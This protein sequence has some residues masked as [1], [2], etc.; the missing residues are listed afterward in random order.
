MATSVK[1][2]AATKDRLEEL[3]ALIKL[4][5]GTKVTQQELLKVLVDEAY[6]SRDEIVDHFR[7]DEWEG[8][9]D[10]E[11]QEWLSGTFSAGEPIGEDEDI[12]EIIYREELENLE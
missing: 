4:E 8:L 2:D 3:Q 7:D 6:S 9:S 1:M 12:D 11:A 10:E 5:T